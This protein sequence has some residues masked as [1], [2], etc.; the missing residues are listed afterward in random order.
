M[1]LR[2]G[3]QTQA[4]NKILVYIETIR[5]DQATFQPILGVPIN[6]RSSTRSVVERQA[7]WISVRG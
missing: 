4:K 3:Y 5:S 2:M 1:R 7:D 6:W